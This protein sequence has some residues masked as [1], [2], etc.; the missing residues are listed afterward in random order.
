MRI[1][2]VTAAAAAFAVTGTGCGPSEP[3]DS[4]YCVDRGN[5]VVDDQYCDDNY[6]GGGSSHG[7]FLWHTPGSRYYSRGD[8]VSGGTLVRTDDAAGRSRLGLPSSGHV[9]SGPISRGGFGGGSYTSSG[10]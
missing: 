5:H 3:E 9:Y 6:P 1:A 7:Y 8:V 2:L 4:V 10:G